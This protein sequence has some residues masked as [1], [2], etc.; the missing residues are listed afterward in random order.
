MVTTFSHCLFLQPTL[1]A[2]SLPLLHLACPCQCHQWPPC[3]Q[4]L[5][6]LLR[7]H[8]TSPVCSLQQKWHSRFLEPLSEHHSCSFPP[9]SLLP[10]F[11]TPPP[12]GL[13]MA[14]STFSLYHFFSEGFH[15]CC[16][17][18][19]QLSLQF[20]PPSGNTDSCLLFHVNIPSHMHLK[21]SLNKRK[22]VITQC[23]YFSH[24]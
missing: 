6:S 21:F 19:Y 24:L 9:F 16:C 23:F 11:P 7:L 1:H 18:K 10:L 14:I 20:L 3:G 4:I 5:W 13:E 2:L 12:L 8:F 15:D 17:F 22:F